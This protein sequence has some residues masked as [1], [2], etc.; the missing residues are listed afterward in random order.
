MIIV[1]IAGG[2]GTRLWPLSTPDYPKQLLTL[3]GENSLIQNTVA[4]AQQMSGEVYVLPDISHSHHIKD[5][6]PGLPEDHFIIEPGRRGTANCF[7]A[8]LAY[9]GRRHG[10][11]EPVAFLWAD[12]HI[13]DTQ[14]FV[15][16]FQ[17]AAGISEKEGVITLIG[18]EPT[19]PATGFGYI[20]RDGEIDS[21][22][23][24]HRVESFKEKPDFKT[25]QKYVA[26]GKYLW[27]CGYFVGSVN[28]FL[29]EMERSA[30]E[31]KA[32]YD[33]LVTF[34]D[35]SE[36][37]YKK[38]YLGFKNEVI[39]TALIEKAKKLAVVS[40]TFDWKDL[41]SFADLH[42]VSEVDESGN[43]F[44]GA[45]VYGDE[46]EN[47]YIRNEDNR[48]VVVIGLDNIVVV[49]TEHGV[50]VTRKDISQ[51]VKDAVKKIEKDQKN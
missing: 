51:R 20:E 4:R 18:I 39:D 42:D 2:S 6:L 8:A 7:V 50:L 11:D 30:P 25:A 33:A 37:A 21:T 35:T 10:K 38:T 3:T 22:A 48:P 12:H 45:N 40:A 26:S 13:R 29:E 17:V 28:T 36:D 34:K 49:N 5:Q 27:N 24:V 31:L 1:I 41:G 32:N 16:S 47:T 14:G 43:H 9:V 46:V 23:N 15:R 19:H 44:R